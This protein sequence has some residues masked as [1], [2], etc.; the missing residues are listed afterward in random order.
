MAVDSH[1]QTTG[2]ES[3]GDLVG[4]FTG[5]GQRRAQWRPPLPQRL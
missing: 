1:Q 5:T 3:V 2:V 4:A